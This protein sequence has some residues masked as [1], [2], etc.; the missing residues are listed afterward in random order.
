MFDVV[1][2]MDAIDQ[3][4]AQRH[5]TWYKVAQE[6]CVDGLA[7]RRYRARMQGMNVQTMAKLAMWAGLDAQQFVKQQEVM[8]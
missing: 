6:S 1:G 5:T 7:L 4:R 3:V 2:F 8:V